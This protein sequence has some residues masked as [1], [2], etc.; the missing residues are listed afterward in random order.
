MFSLTSQER[1]VL[2][3]VISVIFAGTT[4]DYL[5]KCFPEIADIVNVME[6]SR[7]YTKVNI[8]TLLARKRYAIEFLREKL[9]EIYDELE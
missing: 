3:I 1:L 7:L 5:F 6:T 8:N 9:K 4:L 2:I